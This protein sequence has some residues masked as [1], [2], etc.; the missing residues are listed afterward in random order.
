M[1][2]VH[3]ILLD[4]LLVSMLAIVFSLQGLP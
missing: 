3:F 4:F 1:K 2:L